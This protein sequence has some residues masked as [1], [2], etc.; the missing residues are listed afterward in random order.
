MV[1]GGFFNDLQAMPNDEF[2]GTILSM[3]ARDRYAL[4]EER[5]ADFRWIVLWIVLRNSGLKKL[6]KLY[7]S[8]TQS[9]NL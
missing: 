3:A 6:S 4:V 2:I 5:R 7:V 1:V 9:Q 8:F